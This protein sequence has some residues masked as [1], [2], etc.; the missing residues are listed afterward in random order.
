MN[1]PD[2]LTCHQIV[3][4]R[5][6]IKSD[7]WKFFNEYVKEL[8]FAYLNTAESKDFLRGLK[9]AVTKFEEEIERI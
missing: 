7:E 3:T 2:N 4:L 9:F 6:M 5:G 1:F 8:V